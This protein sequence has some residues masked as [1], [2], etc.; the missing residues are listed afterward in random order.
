MKSKKVKIKVVGNDNITPEEEQQI[1][2]EVF[3]LLLKKS[4][5]EKSPAVDQESQALKANSQ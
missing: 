4:I 1:W 5:S 3:D 2:N